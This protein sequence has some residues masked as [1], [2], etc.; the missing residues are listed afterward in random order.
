MSLLDRIFQ[1]PELQEA[2]PVLVDVGAAG[3]IHP[4]W[5]C[6][7]RH[8]IGLGFEPDAREAAVLEGAHRQFRKWIFCP[9]VV[10]PTA[11]NATT[12]RL[13]RSPQCSS[14][15]EPDHQRLAEWVFA[16]RFTV[17]NTVTVAAA[18]LQKT[19]ENA[20]LAGVDWIKLDTQG[21]DLRLFLSLPS[22][23]R[24]RLIVAEFEPGFID[25]YQ[26]EDQIAQV[27]STMKTAPFWLTSM[28][29]GKTPRGRSELMAA[30]M[31]R[32]LRPWLDR[33]APQSPGW[34]ELRFMRDVT[35][36][37]PI[38]DRRGWL[39]TWVFAMITEQPGYA[40]TV[41]EEGHR[42]FGGE[43][44]AEMK[45]RSRLSVRWAMI[46]NLPGWAWRRVWR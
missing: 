28:T 42:R 24:D 19:L 16:D 3:Q 1:E 17:L 40:L 46:R 9:C 4:A 25:A 41:A 37:P 35:C 20:G 14:L 26:G 27:L 22:A 32:L 15:L 34:A 18:T 5:R 6:I 13:T 11:E 33:L 2:P 29:L 31:P 8:S 45:G 44:F 38:L 30:E 43:L 7:A 23:W 10:S 36:E 21:M 12:L 39:L